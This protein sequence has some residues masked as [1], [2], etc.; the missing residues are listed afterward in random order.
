M[1]HNI[2]HP[3]SVLPWNILLLYQYP[4]SANMPFLAQS[5]WQT[6]AWCI[7]PLCRPEPYL[8][9]GKWARQSNILLTLLTFFLWK[10][11]LMAQVIQ[12]IRAVFQGK[13]HIRSANNAC[14]LPRD[15]ACLPNTV[16]RRIDIGRFDSRFSFYSVSRGLV[17]IAAAGSKTMQCNKYHSLCLG[18]CVN[19][20]GVTYSLLLWQLTC[21]GH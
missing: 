18:P 15:F 7:P 21:G 3:P 4:C 9:L 17:R 14:Q 13:L 8:H 20:Q 2:S 1:H 10:G 16:L 19:L 12:C 6:L 11:I 5:T